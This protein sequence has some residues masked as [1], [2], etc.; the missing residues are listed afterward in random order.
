MDEN[1]QRE[2][3]RTDFPAPPGWLTIDGDRISVSTAEETLK[4]RGDRVLELAIWS[5]RVGRLPA[6]ETLRAM[7]RQLGLVLELPRSAWHEAFAALLS[8]AQPSV[9]LQLL[10]QTHVLPVMLPEVSAMVGFH[11]SCPVHHKDIWDHTL[12]VVDK[13]PPR[14]AV[15]W[16]ALMHDA[17]KIWTRSVNARGKV[18]FFRHEELGA[19]LMSGV[20]QRFAMP[21][22]FGDRVVYIIAHHARANVYA[23]EW[24]D[25][26]VRRL[27]RD[28]GDNL[29]D[30]IAFSQ[31]DYTTKRADRIREVQQLAAELNARIDRIRI[32][33]AQPP[34][35]PKGVG[36][37]IMQR[38]G[39]RGGP[40]LGIVQRWLVDQVETGAIA[41]G[42]TADAYADHVQAAAPELLAGA[43]APPLRPG[44]AKAV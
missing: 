1:P 6:R 43:A 39:V 36:N 9:G 25:T 13:C 44:P 33:D 2:P 4:D 23:T 12:K 18:H 32:E 27:I 5:A 16:A 37:V 22:E 15:R 17:G 8:A 30:V 21:T 40:W 20:A 19:A 24:T 38:T 35:L 34:P 42:L 29:D 31:S 10:Q 26:A 28:F 3:P 11:K 14:V 41:H 7:R